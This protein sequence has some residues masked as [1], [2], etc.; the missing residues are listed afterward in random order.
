M[1]VVGERG[2]NAQTAIGSVEPTTKRVPAGPLL[3][4]GRNLADAIVFLSLA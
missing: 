4:D 1:K 3:G 2:I